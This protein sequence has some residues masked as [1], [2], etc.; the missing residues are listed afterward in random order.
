LTSPPSP[1]P[2]FQFIFYFVFVF[3]CH[4]S[5]SW[6]LGLKLALPCLELIL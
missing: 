3:N 6:V 2:P 5:A 4:V 1:P